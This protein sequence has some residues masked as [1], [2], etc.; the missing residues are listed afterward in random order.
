MTTTVTV[1]HTGELVHEYTTQNNAIDVV[2]GYVSRGFNVV[3]VLPGRS[4]LLAS[5]TA[6]VVVTKNA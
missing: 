4:V 5:G 6:L 2:S 3:Q 1:S